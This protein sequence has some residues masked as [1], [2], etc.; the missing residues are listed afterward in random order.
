MLFIFFTVYIRYLTSHDFSDIVSRDAIFYLQA[1]QPPKVLERV[2]GKN[3]F[4]DSLFTFIDAIMKWKVSFKDIQSRFDLGEFAVSVFYDTAYV[5]VLLVHAEKRDMEDVLYGYDIYEVS[6]K[7]LAI[8]PTGTEIN[9][10]VKINKKGTLTSLVSRDFAG[11]YPI[12]IFLDAEHFQKFFITRLTSQLLDQV[13]YTTIVLK[14]KRG[15]WVFQARTQGKNAMIEDE[16]FESQKRYIHEDVSDDI[17][18]HGLKKEIFWEY[19]QTLLFQNMNSREYA[20]TNFFPLL[21]PTL[22]VAIQET[23][24]SPS[25][26]FEYVVAFL[27]QTNDEDKLL[28]KLQSSLSFI[29]PLKKEKILPDASLVYEEIADKNTVHIEY[30]DAK[31]KIL[32]F[33]DPQQSIYYY[34]DK[35]IVVLSNS[36]SYLQLHISQAPLY[37]KDYFE[38]YFDCD[39]YTMRHF[40]MFGKNAGKNFF[41][42]YFVDLNTFEF[43][44]PLLDFQSLYIAG[45]ANGVIGCML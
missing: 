20:R 9:K 4:P 28:E 42:K 21:G 35:N 18:I 45:R 6:E 3:D 11:G 8:A 1:N 44:E 29:F 13:K 31:N 2:L 40:I 37:Q 26:G 43:I 15:N 25:H 10:Y 7:I 19:A 24:D 39:S 32:S 34:F 41:A 14:N 5:P 36:L 30:K 38:E 12:K 33:G 16:F 17:F 22:D 27:A 23:S